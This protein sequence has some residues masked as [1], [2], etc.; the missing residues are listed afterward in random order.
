MQSVDDRWTHL[1]GAQGV[2]YD[3]RPALARAADDD[4]AA[5]EELWHELHDDGS[6]DLAS[7]AAVPALVGIIEHQETFDPNPWS[8][9]ATVE[10]HR[11]VR[12]NPAVPDWLWDEYE[13]AMSRFGELALQAM[14][15]ADR[16]SDVCLLLGAIAIWKGNRKL[17]SVLFDIAPDRA[18]RQ[19]TGSPLLDDLIVQYSECD[20]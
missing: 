18:D 11:H 2:L 5:W 1:K 14:P 12:R 13:A 20:T 17:A 9:V 19:S 15:F 8:L 6:V 10:L 4:A 3:P 16:E 7:Y